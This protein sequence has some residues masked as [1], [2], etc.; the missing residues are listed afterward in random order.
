MEIA[1]WRLAVG[2]W[3][4][5]AA[6]GG[7]WQLVVGGWW[8]LVA[9]DS[10][11]LV[12]VGGWRRLVVGGWWLLAVG[13]SW[14]LA[15]GGPLGQSIRAVVNKKRKKIWSLKDRPGSGERK[16]RGISRGAAPRLALPQEAT[17]EPVRLSS[18]EE[19]V[20]Q[21]PKPLPQLRTSGLRPVH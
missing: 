10:W 12:A 4:R 17:H 16:A 18:G 15:V 19:R 7:S 1:G 2:G 13:G 6:V 8:R 11:R 5:S 21:S 9:V 3:R 20:A 14:R